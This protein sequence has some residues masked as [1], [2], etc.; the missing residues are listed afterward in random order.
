MRCAGL[1]CAALH[2]TALHTSTLHYWQYALLAT[3]H[4]ATPQ[5][6]NLHTTTH[7]SHNTLRHTT[8]YAIPRKPASCY[9]VSRHAL[10]HCTSLLRTALPCTAPHCT[11]L[12][13][14]STLPQCYAFEHCNI[15]IRRTAVRIIKPKPAPYHASLSMP[16]TMWLVLLL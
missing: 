16:T 1:H 9:T 2:C 7:T 13:P 8:H 12:Q 15:A 14:F 10:L 4:K 3:L 5:C 6:V 11:R